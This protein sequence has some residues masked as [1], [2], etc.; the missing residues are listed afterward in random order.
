MTWPY[1]PR[2]GLYVGGDD[3]GV[4]ASEPP[5]LGR[6]ELEVLVRFEH[7]AK[8]LSV[9]EIP[10]AGHLD[11]AALAAAYR[12]DAAT[13]SSLREGF[14]RRAEVAAEE[15]MRDAALLEAV[16]RM[17]VPDGGTV[18]AIGDS[19][20]DD[21]LSWAEILR[22]C[23]RLTRP[24]VRVVNAGISGD[25]TAG[26]LRRLYGIVELAPDLV[27]TLLGTNDCQRHGPELELLVAPNESARNLSAIA[28]WLRSAGA[29]CV[30]ITPPP[31]L[32]DAL[33][34]AV[35]ER[36]FRV[37]DADVS[38]VAR[39]VRELDGPVVDL[40]ARLGEPPPAE[41]FMDDGVHPSP[42]GQ[43]AIAAALL[44]RLADQASV[45]GSTPSQNQSGAGNP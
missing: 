8:L 10:G 40:R 6:A 39:I 25:T 21:Y 18:V 19:I 5:P 12:S 33:V 13:V 15:L 1:D 14:R 3:F 16:R 11:G 42:A 36:P 44:R 20:T 7:P 29:R 31:V 28:R 38:A 24:G 22:H 41:L 32:E 43:T 27:V 23:I 9:A 4:P 30:W 45:A 2:A 35:G 37:R 17:P 34:R 26:T